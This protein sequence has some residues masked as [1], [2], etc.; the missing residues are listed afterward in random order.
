[1]CRRKYISVVSRYILEPGRRDTRDE[2]L[3]SGLV[4]DSRRMH[5]ADVVVVQAF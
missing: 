1:M 5:N 3:E 2:S 4:A